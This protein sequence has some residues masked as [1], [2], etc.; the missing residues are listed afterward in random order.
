MWTPSVTV[1]ILSECTNSSHETIRTALSR[2]ALHIIN[3]N[4]L[5][6]TL[7]NGSSSS[8]GHEQRNLLY[9]Q[10]WAEQLHTIHKLLSSRWPWR[11]SQRITSWV[12]GA[13]Y[14]IRLIRDFVTLTL[15]LATVRWII[16]CPGSRCLTSLARSGECQRWSDV[17]VWWPNN[18]VS[19]Q[20]VVAINVCC[21]WWLSQIWGFLVASLPPTGHLPPRSSCCS[22]LVMSQHADLCVYECPTWIQRGLKSQTLGWYLSGY[23]HIWRPISSSQANINIPEC[24]SH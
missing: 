17:E 8:L 12:T 1:L 13:A 11:A 2:T 7:C 21:L 16:P 18:W 22:R 5:L 24:T 23:L 9:E 3:L 15:E 10:L 4:L 6:P 14:I 20:S 19:A